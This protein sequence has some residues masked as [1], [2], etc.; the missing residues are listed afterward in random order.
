VPIRQWQLSAFV[1]GKIQRHTPE[2]A[3]KI[4]LRGTNRDS[5]K[6]SMV[7]AMGQDFSQRESAMPKS[8][9]IFSDGTGQAG[10]LTPDQSI[11]GSI[12]GAIFGQ[13][14]C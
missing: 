13:G 8:I 7:G 5:L 4:R 3:N 12:M 14:S 9:L 2:V 1:P 11:F 10:G 6:A